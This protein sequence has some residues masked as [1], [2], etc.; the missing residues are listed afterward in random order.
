M[1]EGLKFDKADHFT[2]LAAPRKSCSEAFFGQPG[3][4]EYGDGL[5]G[6]GVQ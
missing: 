4:S 2:G 1:G 6:R 5:G 3:D